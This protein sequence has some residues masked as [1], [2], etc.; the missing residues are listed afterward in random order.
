MSRSNPLNFV[1]GMIVEIGAIVFIVSLLPRVDLRPVAEREVA[2]APLPQV[3]EAA[4]QP[5]YAVNQTSYYQPRNEPSPAVASP[6]QPN[7][8][9]LLSAANQSQ[10]QYVAQRL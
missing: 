8:P 10:S 2:A 6:P 3:A 7:P 4:A 9:P 5:N 1:L